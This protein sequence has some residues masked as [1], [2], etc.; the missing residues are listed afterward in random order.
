VCAVVGTLIERKATEADSLPQLKLLPSWI[1]AS[2]NLYDVET[3][4]VYPLE[5]CAHC[6]CASPAS[7]VAV[8][9]D[10]GTSQQLWVGFCCTRSASGKPSACRRKV[11][12]WL[13]SMVQRLH[14]ELAKAQVAQHLCET[15]SYCDRPEAS[16]TVFDPKQ[17]SP[18]IQWP[19][20]KLSKCGFCRIKAYCSRECQRADWK[21]GHKTTCTRKYQLPKAAAADA[22][23]ASERATPDALLEVAD[24][25]SVSLGGS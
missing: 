12:R 5:Q 23:T 9:L 21:A 6:K 2:G 18:S 13:H 11:M 10:S 8:P 16:T 1:C 17:A 7:F 4:S 15:C 14:P 24:A 25:V 20:R 19:R 3:Q 22:F